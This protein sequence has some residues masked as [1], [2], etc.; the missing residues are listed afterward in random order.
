MTGLCEIDH[1]KLE[2]RMLFRISKDRGIALT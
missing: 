1:S 2:L